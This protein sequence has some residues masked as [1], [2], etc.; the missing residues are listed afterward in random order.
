[1][2]DRDPLGT[3]P[4]APG[5]SKPAK[6]RWQAEVEEAPKAEG[7]QVGGT[8]GGRGQAGKGVGPTCPKILFAAEVDTVR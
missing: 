3:H 5:P 4:R 7:G 6:R 2:W 8:G 1:M